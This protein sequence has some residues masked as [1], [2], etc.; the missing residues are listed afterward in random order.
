MTRRLGCAIV[1]AV[2]ASYAGAGVTIAQG[3]E[4]QRGVLHAFEQRVAAYAELSRRIDAGFPPLAPS[5][6][7]QMLT[8]RRAS[9]AAAVTAERWDAQQGDIFDA[10]V[11]PALREV[12]A[13]ALIGVD[14][15]LMMADLFEDCDVPADFR[16]QVNGPYPDSASHAM[17]PVL[18]A[19]LPRLPE[20]IQYRLVNRDLVLWDVSADVII[21][22]LSDALP[23]I[24]SSEE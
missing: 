1:A 12:I 19:A 16:P 18:L 3:P 14:L 2:V 8:W 13:D 11:A 20:G 9:V 15:E 10:Q 6:D 4:G 21:D 7:L 5:A 17:P 24:D 22:V 23:I